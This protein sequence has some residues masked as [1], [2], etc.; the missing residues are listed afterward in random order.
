VS[1]YWLFWLGVAVLCGFAIPEVYAIRSQQSGD[2]L[3]ENIR[4]W[5]RT[6]T[7]GGGASWL[8][9]WSALAAILVWLLGHILRW[10]P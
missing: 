7:P 2:T 8:A 5:L 4:R 9:V 10:W 3:S 6:D 1:G